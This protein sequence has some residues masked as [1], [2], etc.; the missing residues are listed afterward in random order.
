[1]RAAIGD[2]GQRGIAVARGACRKALVV[3]D[4]RN[5]LAD[6]GLVVDN[7]NVTR[8][9]SRPPRQLPVAALIFASLL[10]VSAGPLVCGS[11]AFVSLVRAWLSPVCSFA[12]AA[13]P[14]TAN[15][16]RIHAPRWPGR[17]SEA[18]FS[19]MRPPWSS[20]T[21]PTIAR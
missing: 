20:S 4:A 15:R 16:R 9:G 21:R 11:G 1:M 10:V 17:K 18:S 14:E 7:Q 12:F 19:S 3:E 13:W 2:F 6:I 8:H 5:Q